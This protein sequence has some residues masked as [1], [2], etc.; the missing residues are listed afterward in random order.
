MSIFNP[1]VRYAMMESQLEQ[2]LEPAFPFVREFSPMPAQCGRVAQRMA[3]CGA[4]SPLGSHSRTTEIGR[5]LAIPA[6]SARMRTHSPIPV[7]ACTGAYV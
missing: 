5:Y 1:Q 2:P 6:A 3:A 4:M 7:T